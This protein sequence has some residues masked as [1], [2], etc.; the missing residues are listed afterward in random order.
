MRYILTS[1]WDDGVANLAERLVHQL[2]SGKQVLWLVSGGSNIPASVEV[3]D[4]ISV[5]L[6]KHLT[7]LPADE[8]YGPVGHA[9]SNLAQLFEAGLEPGQAQVLAVLQ[10]GLS[11]E[12]TIRHYNQLAV[13]AFQRADY[14][15]GQFGIGDDGH[16]AGILPDSPAASEETALAVGYE[17]PDF[18]R[19][20]L[21]FPA[22]K[23]V[24]VAFTFAFGTIKHKALESLAR[25]NLPLSQQ[26]AQVLKQLPEAYMY[27]DQ[28]GVR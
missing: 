7:I 27:N 2:A 3:A 17:G 1:G 22:I 12:Q 5:K 16:I 14:I 28:V 13:Q 24:D 10:A 21:T 9:D 18:R 15:L 20:T 6:S 4:N 23:Q 11:F 8:R 26:P 25:R 19:L